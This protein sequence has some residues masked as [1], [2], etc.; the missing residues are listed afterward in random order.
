M[1]RKAVEDLPE[2]VA[3][4]AA[5]TYFEMVI[6]RVSNMHNVMTTVIPMRAYDDMVNQMLAKR[7]V[8]V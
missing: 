7:G 4:K 1:H 8:G 6:S 3:L 5:A 2:F